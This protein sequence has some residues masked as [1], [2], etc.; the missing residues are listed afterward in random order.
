MPRKIIRPLDG[1]QFA[2]RSLCNLLVDE[3]R[4]PHDVGQPLVIEHQFPSTDKKQI[5]VIWDKF[6]GIAEQDRSELILSAFEQVEGKPTR[7]KILF[8]SGF[9]VPEAA[10][11]GILPFQVVPAKVAQV[12]VGTEQLFNAMKEEGASTVAGT[13]T[14]RFPT[15]EDA[16]TTKTRLDHRLPQG[17]WLIVQEVIPTG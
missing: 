3:L 1:S 10:A 17:R 7:D 11:A 2:D 12:E 14:L 6:E 8:A 15:F 4:S 5:Q 16:E 9:T 13:T